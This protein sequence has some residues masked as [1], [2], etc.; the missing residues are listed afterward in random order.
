[1]MARAPRCVTAL[2]MG[3]PVPDR[4]ERAEALR[5]DLPVPRP[6]QPLSDWLAEP[7]EAAA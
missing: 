6:E 1:M 7:E 3:D 4:L 2:L 5:L